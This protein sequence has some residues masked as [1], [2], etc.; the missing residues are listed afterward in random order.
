MITLNLLPIQ[1][2]NKVLWSRWMLL[3]H[4]CLIIISGVV[5]VV[6][7]LVYITNIYYGEIFS[8]F[9]GRIAS[10]V[11]DPTVKTPKA[12]KAPEEH[13]LFIKNVNNIGA[14]LRGQL[15]RFV[16][17][18][19]VV[20]GIVNVIP[21]DVT[22]QKIDIDFKGNKSVIIGIAKNYTALDQSIKALND[23]KFL[24]NSISRN[25]LFNYKETDADLPFGFQL[26]L[27][28]QYFLEN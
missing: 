20:M 27:K 18:S 5:L 12:F 3:L 2:R 10:T 23:S 25:I 4:K 15:D 24:N 28:M 22:L 26:Q 7:F 9:V 6:A 17:M 19:K 11:I 8:E 16:L 13:N 21:K 1:Y 14:S